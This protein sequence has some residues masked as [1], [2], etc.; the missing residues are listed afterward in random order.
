LADIKK[1]IRELDEMVQQIETLQVNFMN[2]GNVTMVTVIVENS[3]IQSAV[4]LQRRM[5]CEMQLNVVL[6]VHV[7][8]HSSTFQT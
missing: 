7:A 2:N 6:N 3:Q 4:D 8:I 1:G 5:N